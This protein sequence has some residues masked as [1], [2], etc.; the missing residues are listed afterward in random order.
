MLSVSR[1][2][3]LIAGLP[4][5][6]IALILGAMLWHQQ[7]SLEGA[8]SRGREAQ[9]RLVGTLLSSSFEQAA[10]F[11]L[12]LAES[13]ARNAEIRDA[14]AAEDRARLQ[15]LS[16]E[17]YQYL[18]R[19]ANVQIFGYHG[20]DLRYLLRMH[21]P[22][23]H[24]DDISAFRA[25]IV[26]ANRLRRAQTGVEI[27]IAGIGIR[28]VALVQRGEDF[29]G[30][31]EIGFDLRPLIELV[32]TTTNSEIAVIAAASLTG[33][34]LDPK[35]PSVGELTIM[36]STDDPIFLA[37]LRSQTIKPLRDVE[38]GQKQIGERSY[39]FMSQPLV[40][41]SGKLV[42]TVLMLKEDSQSDWRRLGTELWV[43]ALCGGILAFVGFLVLSG[44]RRRLD[45]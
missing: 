9:M 20:K 32:K 45:A 29:L 13:F 33:V 36:A 39:A 28:G 35:L 24:G 6:L 18:G 17:A 41:F 14:L 26:A 11:S 22:D 19:Q 31:M 4:A 3:L 16:N 37:L 44:Q 34:A 5:L 27:G 25:M 43:I 38:I 8:A 2:R 42:G 10:K 7:R 12:S 23:Q 30:T 21:R 40:D 1:K 15:A